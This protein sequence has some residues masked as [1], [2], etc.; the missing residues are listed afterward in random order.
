MNYYEILGV[1]KDAS[2]EEID[3]SYKRLARASHPDKNIGD[4]TAEA[5]FKEIQ[6]AYDVVGNPEKRSHYDLYGDTPNIHQSNNGWTNLFGG[7]VFDQFFNFSREP[8]NDGRHIETEV[9]ISF[10]EAVNGCQKTIDFDRRE[11]CHS[12]KGTG[13]KD[14]KCMKQCVVCDGKG[15]VQQKFSNG[16]GFM[17]IERA[18]S[19]CRGTGT[20]I[21]EFCKDCHMR[22]FTMKNS[23]IS[24]DIPAGIDDGMR[25]C[26]REQ[27]DKGLKGGVGNLY[28]TIRVSP[29]Q[30]FKRNGVNVLLTVPITYSQAVL[31]SQ[32]EIPYLY[33]K[34]E[35]T[36]PKGVNSGTTFRLEGLGFS[37]FHGGK[38]DFFVKVEID[39]PK[40]ISD[41]YNKTLNNL[42]ELE[43]LNE[44]QGIISFKTKVS[45]L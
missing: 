10:M 31:G 33:G 29:H 9:S 25:V 24:V 40:N 34:C 36:V 27:G 4:P 26:L 23:S 8:D 42:K 13:A 2:Q 15:K 11:T 32:I 45:E 41:E 39:I 44:S 6:G 18:C 7:D 30:L 3:K 20:V 19:S 1:E 43:K 38:G 37:D 14:G 12:C 35:F 16:G 21:S 22:G 28:C 5:K 17:R